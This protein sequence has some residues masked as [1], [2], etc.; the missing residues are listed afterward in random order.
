MSSHS[1]DVI[2][3]YVF[4]PMFLRYRR[5][6]FHDSGRH[7]LSGQS[8]DRN[9]N[10]SVS[11]HSFF[12]VTL[13][14]INDTPLS[15]SQYEQRVSSACSITMPV[16]DG[17]SIT[18]T[19]TSTTL[20]CFGMLKNLG[21]PHSVHFRN[22]LTVLAFCAVAAIL[23]SMVVIFFD[24]CGGTAPFVTFSTGISRKTITHQNNPPAAMTQAVLNNCSNNRLI[25]SSSLYHLT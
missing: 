17:P 20:G 2:V 16:F 12:S 24:A 14:I 21:L 22:R 11:E 13:S 5:S 3:E 6:E 19:Y 23:V 1:V 25:Q 7:T 15:L 9:C 10:K 8:I 18:T 4:T